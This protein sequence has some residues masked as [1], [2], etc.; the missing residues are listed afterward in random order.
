MVV[1]SD[2]SSSTTGAGNSSSSPRIASSST[3]TDEHKGSI[4]LDMLSVPFVPFN[5]LAVSEPY[6]NDARNEPEF[7]KGALLVHG[8]IYR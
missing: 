7:E 3:S 6:D 1:D 2:T 4:Q 5:P 8:H